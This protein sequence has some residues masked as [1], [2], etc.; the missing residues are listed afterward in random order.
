MRKPTFS[1]ALALIGLHEVK[2][3]T[4][5][6][7][8][9]AGEEVASKISHLSCDITTLVALTFE[10]IFNA[11]SESLLS[12]LC[13]LPNLRIHR[14]YYGKAARLERTTTKYFPGLVKGMLKGS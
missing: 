2:A 9:K 12:I 7:N 11:S 14:L 6:E 1:S 3:A 5:Q 4:T 10:T 8:S 13:N